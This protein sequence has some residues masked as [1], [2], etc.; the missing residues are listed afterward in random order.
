VLSVRRVGHG[1]RKV[2]RL[3]SGS[4]HVRKLADGSR[5]FRLRFNANGRRQI[6]SLHERQG[7]ECGCGGG[8]DERAARCELAETVSRI[9]LGE[10]K[11]PTVAMRARRAGSGTSFAAYAQRWLQAKTEGL[12]GE[13]RPGTAADYRWCV[14]RHLLPVFEDCAVEEIDRALCLRFKARLLSDARELRDALESGR[15]LR[16]ERGRRRRPLGPASVRKVLRALAAILEDAVED[17]LIESNPARGKRMRVRV[18]KPERTFLEMDELALLLEAAGAQDEPLRLHEPLADLGE[19]SL[20]VAR[21]LERGYRPPQIAKRLGLRR[22][23]ISFHMYRLGVSVGRCYAGRRVAVEILGRSGVRVSELCDLRIGQV[24]LHGQ[25][26]GRF[27][28]V[29]SKTETGVREV[30]MTPDLAAVISAH[31]QRLRR[32]NAPTGPNAFLV[33]NLRGG[34]TD[35]GRIAHV[36][37]KASASA[38]EQQLARG[39][40]PLPHTTPHTLRRTYISI[41]L[42]ANNF[43]V[44]WVMAQVGHADSRMTMDVYAQL[45]Q[46]AKRDHGARFD[47]LVRQARDINCQ[48]LPTPVAA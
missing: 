26:G 44:K 32:V 18:P 28:I 33:P 12:F 36:L 9:R 7:C 20:R 34:R 46:R 22:S 3:N 47:R 45:E 38:S 23:T 17:E 41:A 35:R 39:L 24:R 11:R 4:L 37:T 19:T 2:S 10:W 1:D 42:L 5:V 16:D 25:D 8:W 31:I 48:P 21:L 29:D 30:Q 27:R 40:P 13:I 43:D 6:M 15:D 14:E